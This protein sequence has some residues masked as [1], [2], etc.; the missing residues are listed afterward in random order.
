M[1]LNHADV[2]KAI[3]RPVDDGL[4]SHLLGSSVPADLALGSTDGTLV[5]LNKLPGLTIVFCYPRTGAPGEAVPAEWNNTP[6]ARGCTAEACSYRDNFS[7][8]AGLGVS[9]VFGLS[10]QDT[11]Y[12]KEVKGRLGLPYDLLSDEKLEFVKAMKMPVFE[13]EG[14]PL[15]KRCT[16]AFREGK[17]EHVWYP[18]FPPD[19]NSAEVAAWLKKKTEG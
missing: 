3:P 9:A 2:P 15:V 14:R 13:W 6:G 17:V 5:N 1:A 16:L 10:V 12:Q 7:T 4:A 18:V 11:T 19:E 8:L